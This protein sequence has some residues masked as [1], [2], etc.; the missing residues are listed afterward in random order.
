MGIVRRISAWFL[1]QMEGRASAHVVA[2]FAAVF[3]L[4][5]TDKG[6]IGAMALPLEQALGIGHA[7]LGLLP[8]VSSF[9]GIVATLPFGWLVDRAKRIRVLTT[10]VALWGVAMALG[11]SATSYSYLLATRLG[12]GV[13]IAATVPA[14]AS[15]TGDYFQPQ[16]RGRM[17]G[18]MLAGEMIGT[19]FGYLVPGELALLSWRI[20]FLTS[21]GLALGVA[22]L[23]HRLPEPARGGADRLAPGQERVGLRDRTGPPKDQDH[24]GVPDASGLIRDLVRAAD[25]QPR[26]GLVCEENPGRQSLWWAAWYVLHIP[27]NFVLIIA[28]ALGYYFFAGMRTFGVAFA[29]GWFGLRHSAAIGLVLLFGAGGLV[30]ALAGGRLGDYLLARR[31]L[32][33]RIIVAI[34]AYVTAALLLVPALLT[35][36]LIVAAP[37]LLLAGFGLGAVNPPLDAARLDIMHPYL[38]GR[39]ESVRAS[40]RL[41]GEA[42]GPL[43]FGYLAQHV[44]GGG[45]VG[46]QRTFL[47]MLIPLFISAGIGLIAVRTYPRDVATADAYTQRTLEEEQEKKRP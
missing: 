12:L 14:I 22:W 10:A 25:L 47:I 17:Y 4:D 35:H 18:Y 33:A 24:G 21:A 5:G 38:W 2:V 40:L 13:V 43:L 9:V 29:H 6:A 36:Q 15:L 28:S 32:S 26:A 30:G 41:I 44:L 42:V 7:Q 46:L 37:A 23:V 45:A 11:A 3:A 16:L 31:H 19:A 1:R 20:G 27:T 8:M 34:C 39:A